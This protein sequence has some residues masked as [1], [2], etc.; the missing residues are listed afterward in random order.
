MNSHPSFKAERQSAVLEIV[1][2]ET[3]ATQAELAEALK[4]RRIPA[5][6]VT[7]SRDIAELGLIKVAGRYRPAP[8]GEAAAD[9]E[10]P[11]RTWVR[12]VRPAGPHL[13]V[14]R[15]DVGTAQRVGI[16]IDGL[17]LEGIAGTIAGDDTVFIAVADA[18]ANKRVV[19]FLQS[20]IN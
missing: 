19:A 2:R 6:Q 9:P 18:A 17:A 15:C 14:I 11:L 12:A 20:R 16:V 8:A 13:A 1:A 7:L 4:K 3:V 10:A 5:T